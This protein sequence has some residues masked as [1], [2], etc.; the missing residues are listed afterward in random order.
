M[1]SGSVT[2]SKVE[3]STNSPGCRMN[4]SSSVGL[5]QPGQVRLLIAGSMCGYRWFSKTRK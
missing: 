5:D 2:T 3:P 1:S 4:G